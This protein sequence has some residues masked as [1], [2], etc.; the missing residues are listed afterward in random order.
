M[1][2]CRERKKILISEL[3]AIPER[4]YV[5]YVWGILRSY[6]HHDFPQLN[7]SFQWLDPIFDSTSAREA[8]QPYLGTPIDVLGLSCYT[9]NWD[10]SCTIAQLVKERNPGCLV[11]A[12]GPHPDY[13]S[14]SFFDEHPYIDLVVVN[15]GEI[16]FAKILETVDR[17]G[18]DFQPI[19]GVVV[20]GPDGRPSMAVPPI[21]P[22][23]FQHS[24]YLQYAEF[25]ER[26]IR[27]RPDACCI[28]WETNR[29]CP[30][31][32]SFCDWGSN[33]LSKIRSFDLERVRAEA[34]WIFKQPIV[35][36]FLTDAN[37]GILPR[38]LEIAEILSELR[39]KHHGPS[40]FTYSPAKNNP[41]RTVA[42]A[43]RFA[44]AGLATIHYLA[45]QHTH[46]D[47]LAAT[48]RSNIS[49]E[50]QKEIVRELLA[51]GVPIT[52]QLIVGIPGDSVDKWAQVFADL[53][54]WGVHE[55]YMVA[56]YALLPNAPAADPEFRAK[57][58]HRTVRRYTRNFGLHRRK[59]EE[60]DRFQVDLIVEC[61][62]F[63]RLDW[64]RMRIY[65]SFVIALHNS[66]YTRRIAQ[67]LRF[68]H[69]VS[70]RDFYDS[71]INDF[72]EKKLFSGN[73]WRVLEDN[74]K[75]YLSDEAVCD[76][77]ELEEIPSLTE[78]LRHSDWLMIKTALHCNDFFQQ[79]GS[80]LA[81]R[82]PSATNLQSVIAY[83]KSLVITPDY[84][85]ARGKR[86]RCDHNWADFF[87]KVDE[88][89]TYRP[90]PEP[91]RVGP[92]QV[93]E[94][95]DDATGE[96]KHATLAW[97]GD[98]EQRMRLWAECLSRGRKSA[99][100]Q[101]FDEP[102]LV[103]GTADETPGASVLGLPA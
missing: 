60:R 28:A 96:F 97:K 99:A 101:C 49:S 94:I 7:E 64:A 13:R 1:T 33:T 10:R 5:P 30:Y 76:E 102:K 29:G 27:E 43:K 79:L 47:V 24:P 81:S 35:I 40:V 39:R 17:G 15:D 83:Q 73:W 31:S 46:P 16:A 6:V 11:V 100:C 44:R 86:F 38:D 65:S 23:V 8:V 12:G 53:M 57:W 69:D 54:S 42:I 2:D 20:R 71:V 85:S 45:I 55:D 4:T 77:L 91:E 59:G 50:K 19:P 34:E 70:Y 98:R 74:L 63:T 36:A 84:D 9:W 66:G 68:S 32:C 14:Q 61:R 37:F 41:E 48:E 67:Y 58:Q 3:N 89:G 87:R 90:M 51:D 103:W 78:Y 72:C 18:H 26:I 82:Y 95:R 62:T 56:E 92:G 75:G 88:I 25:Y 80:Y 93:F 22:T 21:K 52:V